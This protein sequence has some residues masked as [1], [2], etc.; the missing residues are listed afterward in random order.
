MQRQRLFSI[1]VVLLIAAGLFLFFRDG[2]VEDEI[3]P[4]EQVL[5]EDVSRELSTQL[6]VTIP[7][8]VER[9][10][11]RDVRDEGATGLATRS[12]TDEVFSHTILAALPELIANTQYQG[13]LVRGSEGDGNYS[14]MSTGVL[15]VSKGG[16]LLEYSSSDDLRDYNQV[17]VTVEVESDEVPETRVLE[18]SF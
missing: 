7:E 4:G 12:Y 16:F 15:R 14:V 11:L 13:W 17:W 10:A 18:G 5:V 8:D 6:G 3:S 2:R 9:I 1:L